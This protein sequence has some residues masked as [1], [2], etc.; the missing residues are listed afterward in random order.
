MT[1]QYYRGMRCGLKTKYELSSEHL[2]KHCMSNHVSCDILVEKIKQEEARDG[3]FERK[4]EK[5]EREKIEKASL[6]FKR[7]LRD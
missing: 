6:G 7:I 1:C 4:I 2:L 5:E 3:V